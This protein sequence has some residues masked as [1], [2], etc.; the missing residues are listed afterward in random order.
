[1][2]SGRVAA[3]ATDSTTYG[4]LPA[5]VKDKLVILAETEALP[6][7]VGIARPGLDEKLKAALVEVLLHA[8]EDDAGKKA[9]DSFQGTAKFDEFPQGIDKALERIDE[10]VAIIDEAKSK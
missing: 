5:D 6:R 7:Q 8:H 3:A 10:L 2:L 9:L 4:E 1:V